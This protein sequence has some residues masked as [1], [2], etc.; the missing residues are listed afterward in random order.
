[1]QSLY[2]IDASI[3]IYR[4]WHNTPTSVRNVHN[5]AA[6]AAIGFAQFL[7]HVLEQERPSHIVCA[8]DSKREDSARK[9]LHPFYKANRR[10]VP[11]SLS[12]QFLWCRELAEAMGIN[13]F[14]SPTLE[15][16]DIIGTLCQ[17]ATKQHARNIILS[18]DK[19]LSQFIT[20]HDIYWDYAKKKRYSY[21]EISKRFGVN[22]NQIPDM[23]ALSGDKVDNIPGVPGVGAHTAARLLFK[24]GNLDNLFANI[25]QVSSMKFRGAPYTA[26]LI[27]QHR[28][29]V[30]ASRKLTGLIK[31]SSLPHNLEDYKIRPVDTKKLNALLTYFLLSDTQIEQWMCILEP[32]KNNS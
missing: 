2:L 20:K 25:K 28:D 9:A 11:E 21:R 5:E 24:W 29:T 14:S 26:K 6:N 13:C 19:D 17:Y 7:I 15:A 30:Y 32:S 18:G 23:L 3:Y 10:P 1:M 16:D 8:F 4:A 12:K 31:V 22:P 27:E